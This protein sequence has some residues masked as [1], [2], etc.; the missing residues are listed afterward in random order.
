MT[1]TLKIVYFALGGWFGIDL[2]DPFIYQQLQDLRAPHG[3]F[4][5]EADTNFR[6]CQKVK[7]RNLEE[8]SAVLALG[9]PGALT[10]VDQYANYTNNDSY[11]AIHPL[12]DDILST[13]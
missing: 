10:F 3:L 5:I 9:R 13:T 8:L 4:Q 1:Q 7:P 12:F 11:E 6:V 2:N